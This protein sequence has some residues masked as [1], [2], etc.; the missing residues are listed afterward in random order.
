[1]RFSSL[2]MQCK[3][4]P[5]SMHSNLLPFS[6]FCKWWCIKCFDWMRVIIDCFISATKSYFLTSQS[7]SLK[8]ES[9]SDSVSVNYVTIFLPWPFPKGKP[10]SWSYPG[11]WFIHSLIHWFTSN[12]TGS[13]KAITSL[14]HTKSWSRKS[15]KS[16]KSS[17][18]RKSRKVGK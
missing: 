1:M 14:S 2:F 7:N 13:N 9:V 8:S 15:M 10:R 12:W 16:K 5:H 18:I 6:F 17:K 11:H 3:M 4:L